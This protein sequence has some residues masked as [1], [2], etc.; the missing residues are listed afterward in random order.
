MEAASKPGGGE[1]L[2]PRSNGVEASADSAMDNYLRS[3]GLYRKRV[4]KDGSC[5]FR[6]V[7]EQVFHSQSQ[8]LDI[9]MACI[10][11]LWK[12]R[13]KFEAF[14]EGPFEEYLKTLENPQEWVGQVEISALSLM[15]K[16]DFIIYQEP[17]STPSHVTE[18]G[19]PDKVLLCFSN[20]SHYDIVYPVQYTLSAALC[21]SILYEILYEKV[22]GVDVSKT[23]EE[24][25]P[26]DVTRDGDGNSEAS[27]LED[28]DVEN[29]ITSVSNSN[30]LKPL[31]FHKNGK[32]TSTT[33]SRN[34]LRS[35]NPLVY[36]NIEYEV[37]QQSKREQQKQDFSIAAGMQYSVG[38]K[39]KVRLEPSGKFYN[40]HIQEVQSANGPIVVFVEEL[41]AKH[42][43]FLKNLKPLPQASPVES[44]ST[45]P[46]KKIKRPTPA[47]G[48][49]QTDAECRGSKN[50]N[51][52]IKT[53]SALPPR[54][55]GTRQHHVSGP[56]MHSQQISPEHKSLCRNSSQPARKVDRERTEDFDHTNKDCDYFGLSPK[57]S[58]EKQAEEETRSYYEI[59]FGDEEAFPALSNPSISQVATQTSDNGGRRKLLERRSSSLKE[60]KEERK[61]VEAKEEKDSNPR[62]TLLDQKLDPKICENNGEDP[63]D[64][65]TSP[66]S[67]HGDAQSQPVEENLKESLQDVNSTPS[68]VFPEMHLPPTVPSIPTIVPAWPSEPAYGPTGVTPQMPVSTVIPTPVSGLDSS[69]SQTQV[70]SSPVAAIPVPL[71]AVNQPLMP[72][73]QTLNPYQDPLYP[74]FPLNEKG[75]RVMTPP[76]SLCSTGEDLPNDK[77]ILRFFFNLGVKAYSC[78]MWA[79][80]TYLYPLHQACLTACRMYPKV[81]VPV[82]SPNPWLQEVPLTQNGHEAA[83][84]DGHFPMQNEVRMNGQ[85][86]QMDAMS[87]AVSLFI[88]TAQVPES[89]GLVCVE[90]ENPLQALHAEYDESLG[91]K[92]VFQQPPPFGQNPFLGPVPVAPLFPHLWYGYPVQG[93]VENSVVRQVAVPLEEK[94]ADAYLPKERS[95]P[96]S[97]AGSVE[98]LQKAKSESNVQGLPLPVTTA[99]SEC[100]A[101][102]KTSTRVPR[103][104][105]ACT[106]ALPVPQAKSVLPNPSIE[107]QITKKQV[108]ASAVRD[109][110]KTELKN[111]ALSHKENTDKAGA[112]SNV[113]T[114]LGER[115]V[116]KPREESSEDECEVS[117]MLRSGRSKQF[118]NQTYGSGRRPRSDWSYPS[119]RGGYH[120]PRNEESWKGPFPRNRDEGYHHNRTY[121]GRPYRQERRRANMGDGQRG[122]QLS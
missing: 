1:Q 12:N 56:G 46:G 5:L 100:N 86:P 36:Q 31:Q 70:T 88:P 15:Y 102:N 63:R 92:S 45:V 24:L 122:Q 66:P 4:A 44:W 55:Q 7:A 13:E 59:Q 67:S 17:N 3:Q 53:P 35:L 75:E 80:H 106:A 72:M 107:P 95:S 97:A 71:Q 28:D 87:P 57:E 11:Y 64:P 104:K 68:P 73:P 96:V 76:Y 39:C 25:N 23:L 112:A 113:S 109:L 52:P 58:Q 115:R 108:V 62:Q 114:G 32:P 105:Q 89:Q 79:P 118:Y 99:K 110:P 48:Q 40:A 117:D 101:L 91:G 121:R 33:L 74:G 18:N 49:N 69:L 81:P 78:P 116:Q 47:H 14:I 82:Y 111:A 50:P 84:T 103:E 120:Y 85:S 20:G 6:A 27:D 10:N 22:F 43:V 2:P 38:D 77:N 26:P 9:R 98:S 29:E 16:K 54:L 51:K 61:D 19:F 65:S 34:I 8:H 41:G 60:E 30:G 21:Q 119:G 37:W 90:S 93:Y 94:R 42:S 83:Q